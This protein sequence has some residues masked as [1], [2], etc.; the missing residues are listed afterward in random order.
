MLSFKSLPSTGHN[1]YLQNRK[2]NDIASRP[3]SPPLHKINTISAF[4]KRVSN[5][6]ATQHLSWE[7]QG[8]RVV[9][10]ET[11]C[12]SAKGLQTARADFTA[13]RHSGQS[14]PGMKSQLR[15]GIKWEMPS[16]HRMFKMTF[17]PSHLA[18]WIH[19][20]YRHGPPIVLHVIQQQ[21]HVYKQPLHIQK[22]KG[23]FGSCT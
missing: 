17:L 19:S 13:S 9:G 7:T 6:R 22:L 14:G 21:E 10:S 11:Q 23:Y 16:I 20:N 3:P 1:A 15:A 5:K 8:C 12:C 18:I 2:S 4:N